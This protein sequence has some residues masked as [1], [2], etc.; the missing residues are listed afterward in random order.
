MAEK[1]GAEVV[2]TKIQENSRHSNS[3]IEFY[4]CRDIPKRR[5]VVELL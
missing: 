3:K 4:T 2:W 5:V 1:A